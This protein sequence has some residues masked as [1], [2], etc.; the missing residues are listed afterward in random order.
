MFLWHPWTGGCTAG[1][2][3]NIGSCCLDSRNASEELWVERCWRPD[4][5]LARSAHW[6]ARPTVRLNLRRNLREHWR[7]R[8]PWT[9]SSVVKSSHPAP[10]GW[11]HVVKPCET[12]CFSNLAG[13]LIY[14]K[15]CF[16]QSTF[17]ATSGPENS[18]YDRRCFLDPQ[19]NGRCW[20]GYLIKVSMQSCRQ[21]E[22]DLR[23]SAACHLKPTGCVS[24][25]VVML[26][27]GRSFTHSVS[28]SRA[29][30]SVFSSFVCNNAF[31]SHGMESTITWWWK[32]GWTSRSYCLRL[33]VEAW[34]P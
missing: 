22:S 23:H 33:L 11:G 12:W 29:V 19:P 5:D 17:E 21:S 15:I 30:L 28:S 25:A 2:S 6:H 13:L 4:M 1:S 32:G 7:R 14:I 20:P 8:E 9:G 18:K 24:P 34:S 27:A 26:L 31:W 10:D 16:S 3:Q